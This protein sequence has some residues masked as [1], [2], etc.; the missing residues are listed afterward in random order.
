MAAAMVGG[1]HANNTYTAE[2]IY[3][4]L[5]MQ[6][7]VIDA[8]FKNSVKILLFLGLSSI[9]HKLAPQPLSKD[10]LLTGKL[11]AMC[12]CNQSSCSMIDPKTSS[13]L[14]ACNTACASS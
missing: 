14:P 6:V 8:A 10:V 12:T 11:E 1:V 2:F 4:N 13:S 7:N 5:I 9:Y 3:K